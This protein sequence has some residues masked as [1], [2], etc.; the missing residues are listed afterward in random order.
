MEALSHTCAAEGGG[1]TTALATA[2]AAA[3][4]FP[5]GYFF[6]LTSFLQNKP[7]FQDNSN[8]NIQPVSIGTLSSSACRAVA[9][10]LTA[11]E[12]QEVHGQYIQLQLLD[13]LFTLYYELVH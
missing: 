12:A 7:S 3:A 5:S 11:R 6:F 1:F 9:V 13:P 4:V 8:R 10:A 2:A